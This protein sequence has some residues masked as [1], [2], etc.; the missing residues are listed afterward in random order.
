MPPEARRSWILSSPAI[1]KG[2]VVLGRE[3]YTLGRG[4]DCLIPLSS[5][6]V[7]RRHCEISW[8]THGP[9]YWITDLKSTNGTFVNKEK[10]NV[11]RRLEH[12]D[13][14]TLADVQIRFFLV[15]GD[16]HEIAR[17][18]DPRNEETH[19]ILPSVA[20]TALLAGRLTRTVL[21]EVCQLLEMNRRT[22]ELHVRSGGAHGIL[23]FKEGVIV[24]ASYGSEKGEKAARRILSFRNGEYS[25]GPATKPPEGT[26]K[27][28]ALA[29]V[30][31][32][33]REDDENA[34]TQPLP[35]PR[36][37]RRLPPVNQDD[38]ETDKL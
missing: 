24:D 30:M 28:K 4:T 7:S 3:T 8:G 20:G 32:L 31:D 12:D 14:I 2:F 13:T 35:L 33:A 1:A 27:L 9:G 21:H 11:P 18:H 29:I 34:K 10:V 5:S 19:R 23:H 6:N 16:K 25:F 22:G 17:R 37:T 38:E 36:P 15:E 26:L